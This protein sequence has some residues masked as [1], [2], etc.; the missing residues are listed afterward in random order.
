MV[1]GR[2]DRRRDSDQSFRRAL[3][4]EPMVRRDPMK[5]E[6]DRWNRDTACLD[7]L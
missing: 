7:L 3:V 5:A 1:L 4:P 2:W 6:A